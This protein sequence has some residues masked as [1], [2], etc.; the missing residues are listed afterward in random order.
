MYQRARPLDF[1]FDFQRI[2][3]CSWAKMERKYTPEVSRLASHAVEVPLTAT[4]SKRS[5][6][7]A[8]EASA[9]PA[10]KELPKLLAD[11]PKG[12]WVALSHDDERVLAYGAEL[13]EVLQKA[14]ASGEKD[15]VVIRVPQVEGATLL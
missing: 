14:K 7:F 5:L 4:A 9:M 12:A 6:D 10:V 15:P 13:Q 3:I 11:I 2:A 1:A 8:K